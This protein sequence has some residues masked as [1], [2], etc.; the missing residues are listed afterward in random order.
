MVDKEVP[1][2]LVTELWEAI[3]AEEIRRPVRMFLP[4]ESAELLRETTEGVTVVACENLEDA[5]YH[6]WPDLRPAGGERS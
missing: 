2:P 1:E 4:P 3:E 6:T 5:V